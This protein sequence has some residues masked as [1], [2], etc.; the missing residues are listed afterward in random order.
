MNVEVALE[1]ATDEP[2]ARRLLESVGLD[3]GSVRITDGKP[4]LDSN[5]QGYAAA[6]RYWPWFV[7][8]DLDHDEPCA[9]ALVARLVSNPP[10]RLCL[11]IA[12]RE[13][14]AWLLGDAA[15]FSS[16]FVFPGHAFQ[17]PLNSCTIPSA[18]WSTSFARARNRPS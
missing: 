1:G 5:L 12:V 14:E 13:V 15:R 9:G 17:R 6:A 18:R 7:L 10:L 4:A 3:V 16:S 2:V 8:R 11:R